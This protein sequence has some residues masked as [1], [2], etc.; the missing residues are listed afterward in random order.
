MYMPTYTSPRERNPLHTLTLLHNGNWM[1]LCRK[2][3]ATDSLLI[4]DDTQPT[5][6]SG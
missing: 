6:P 1:C 3:E 4:L 2:T 5:Q